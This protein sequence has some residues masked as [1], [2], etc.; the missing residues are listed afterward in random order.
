MSLFGSGRIGVLI[1]QR[2]FRHR[3]EWLCEDRRLQREEG[4]VERVAGTSDAAT[5][6]GLP[7]AAEQ[8]EAMKI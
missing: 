2:P 7:Q 8:E 3:E 6:Y 5:S 4:F 1:S